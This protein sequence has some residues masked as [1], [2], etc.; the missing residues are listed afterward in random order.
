[1]LKIRL[2][3]T[4]EDINWFCKFLKRNTQIEVIQMS[5]IYANKGTNKYYRMYAEIQKV[6]FKEDKINE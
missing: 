6:E 4:R 5:E 1:M 3:G 2:Q